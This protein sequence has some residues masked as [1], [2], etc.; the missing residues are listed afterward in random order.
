[1]PHSDIQQDSNSQQTPTRV[2]SLLPEFRT[3]ADR[4]PKV[5][6]SP[7]ADHS[8]PPR[9]NS[10]RSAF[11]VIVEEDDGTSQTGSPERLA[12]QIPSHPAR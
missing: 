9:T 1:M 11:S 4:L 7:H 12:Q 5:H 3:N 2:D 8:G 6:E 10:Q